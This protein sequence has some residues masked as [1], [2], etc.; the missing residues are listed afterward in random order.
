MV[1]G[2]ATAMG[3]LYTFS[4]QHIPEDVAY[5]L[6]TIAERISD[7]LLHI[8]YLRVM[9]NPYAAV[10]QQLSDESDEDRVIQALS[11][12]RDVHQPLFAHVHL[13]ATHLS[14]DDPGYDAA[15]SSVDQSVKALVENLKQ[16]GK[17][18]QTLVIFYTDHGHGSTDNV[19]VPLFIRFPAGEHSGVLRNNTQNLD[20]APTILDY[21]GVQPPAWMKGQSLLSGEPPADRPI[22]GA[23]PSYRIE[24]GNRLQLDLSKIKPPF[25]QFG[26]I[27]MVICQKWFNFNTTSLTWTSGD[28]QGYPIPC[29]PGTLP[30]EQ[31]AQ[32]LLLNH[33]SADGFDVS[34]VQLKN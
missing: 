13:M 19:R 15:V 12:F 10:S 5:F 29:P 34:T 33:L 32:Q 4:R 21:L 28:V 17:L 14:P 31:Q 16:M 30:S 23:A 20:I 2:R 18:D 22:F 7:R 27:N 24:E 8:A 26:A 1:N 11:F 3:R 6:S 9:A 25:Y